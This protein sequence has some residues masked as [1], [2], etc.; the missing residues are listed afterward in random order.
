MSLSAPISI[1]NQ[2][3]QIG[4]VL[5]SWAEPLGGT[6][7]VM[8]NMRHLW[9]EIYLLTETPRVLVCFT[10]ETA[11]GSFNE[12]NTLHRV[13][14][15]WIVVVLRGHGFR[16]AMSEP[17]P[18]I[19]EEQPFYDCVESVRDL[20]RTIVVISEEFPIDYKTTR[21]LPGSGPSQQAN[22]FLDA[23]AIEFS[24]A[25]DIPAISMEQQ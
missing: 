25:N 15:S 8:A 6:V 1:T 20:L 13:D 16:N 4:A 3:Q 14:R 17:G 7:K 24:T 23:Y 19:K 22:V 5:A 21:P 11:R 2:A 9:E 10:G 12:A 18:T